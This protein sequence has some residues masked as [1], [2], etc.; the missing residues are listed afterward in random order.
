MKINA[1]LIVFGSDP[2][3]TY[4]LL[5]AIAQRRIREERRAELVR[6]AK[7]AITAPCRLA[8]NVIAKITFYL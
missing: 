4:P 2:T 8:K 7:D 1:P 6:K 3:T 5:M